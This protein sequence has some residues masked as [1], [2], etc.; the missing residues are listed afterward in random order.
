MA[1][2]SS[3]EWHIIRA[4][5]ESSPKEGYAW[6]TVK[7]G[8]PWD[9]SGQ[10]VR[11]K[12]LAD[13]W[14][15]TDNPSPTLLMYPTPSPAPVAVPVVEPKASDNPSSPS[16]NTEE[17]KPV[18]EYEC[19]IDS[20][21]EKIIQE[22]RNE[23]R[24]MRS[25]IRMAIQVLKE[26]TQKGYREG[27]PTSYELIRSAELAMKALKMAHESEEKT[28]GLSVKLINMDEMTPEQWRAIRDGRIPK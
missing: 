5:W 4:Q 13:G 1:Y 27:L 14:T 17:T 24:V 21:R 18:P 9:V 8:G 2:L 12:A 3:D 11:A 16:D 19:E 26:E 28:H 22:H 10:R 7:G 23:V 20:E 25:I 15:K 6:L